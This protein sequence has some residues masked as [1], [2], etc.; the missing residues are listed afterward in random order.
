MKRSLEESD[1]MGST[2][3]FSMLTALTALTTLYESRHGAIIFLRLNPRD[4]CCRRLNNNNFS[5]LPMVFFQLRS[6]K[7][8]CEWAKDDWSTL[9]SVGPRVLHDMNWF[10]TTIPDTVGVLSNLVVLYVVF[11]CIRALV[12]TADVI[13]AKWPGQRFSHRFRRNCRGV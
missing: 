2:N 8:L 4:G 6:L 7:Y 10:P 3:S 1:L 9:I 12:M 5:S 11:L 13:T